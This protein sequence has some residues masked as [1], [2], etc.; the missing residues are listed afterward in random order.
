ML[1]T[2]QPPRIVG[3]VIAPDVLVEIAGEELVP[4][5][6]SA[7]PFETV[8]VHVM[9]LTVSVRARHRNDRKNITNAKILTAVFIR[10]ILFIFDAPYSQATYQKQPTNPNGSHAPVLYISSD[11]FIA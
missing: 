8:Y 11:E 9:P 5:P 7:W 10:K 1:V 3:I 4:P 2:G 6:T